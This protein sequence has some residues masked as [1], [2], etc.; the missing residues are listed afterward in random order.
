MSMASSLNT[1]LKGRPATA[2]VRP[3]HSRGMR[4][5]ALAMVLLLVLVAASYVPTNP[6]FLLMAIATA[7]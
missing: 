4:I 1:I 3:E 2:V 7:G 5:T 6:I